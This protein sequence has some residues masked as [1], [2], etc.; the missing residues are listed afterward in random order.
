M[1]GHDQ[2]GQVAQLGCVTCELDGRDVRRVCSCG[3]CVIGELRMC[4]RV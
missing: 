4:A 1:E 3:L 2:W